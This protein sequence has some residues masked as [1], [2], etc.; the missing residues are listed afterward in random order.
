MFDVFTT[1]VLAAF[2]TNK[3]FEKSDSKIILKT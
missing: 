3:E 2:A 1:I